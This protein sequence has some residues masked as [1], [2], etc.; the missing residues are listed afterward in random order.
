MGAF[1]D[2]IPQS[3][4]AFDDLTPK[5]KPPPKRSGPMDLLRQG[6][7][8]LIEGGA[9]LALQKGDIAALRRRFTPVM[10]NPLSRIIQTGT[11][12][13]DRAVY[14]PTTA[15]ISRNL[16]EP[17]SAAE[18]TARTA[19]QMAPNA[20]MPGTSL[21]RGAA[22]ILPTALS[23]GAGEGARALGASPTGEAVARVG[24]AVAGGGLAGFRRTPLPRGPVA[25]Q[26][27]DA[28]MDNIGVNVRVLPE[29]ARVR[30]AR[31]IEDGR[32]PE[33]VAL[34]VAAS[35]ATP[36]PIP[37]RRGVMTGNP[38][39]QHAESMALRGAYG[40]QP[41]ALM[42]GQVA[43]EQ[44]ALR[45]NIDAFA[46]RFAGGRPLP[47]GQGAT[48]AAERLVQMR[49]DA[50]AAVNAAF[51]AAR[52]ADVG[53]SLPREQGPVLAQRLRE[54]VRDYDMER[55]SSVRNVL[56]SF[57]NRGGPVDARD[58]FDARARLNVLTQSSDGV[59][60]SAASAAKRAL[61]GYIDEASQAGFL[62]DETSQ[63]RQAISQRR[64]VGETFESNDLVEQLTARD[65]RNGDRR[66]LVVD[67][68]EAAN[69]I[70][71]RQ[72]TSAGKRNLYRDVT[73]LRDVVGRDTPEWN[74]LRAEHFQRVAR[75]GEGGVE[76]GERQFSGVKFQKAWEDFLRDDPRLADALYSAEERAQI[77]NFARIAARVTSP[78]K[79]GDNPSNSAVSALKLLPAFLKGLPF[80]NEIAKRIEVQVNI[81]RAAQAVAPQP[82]RLPRRGLFGGR[83][84]AIAG[85]LA[86]GG[87]RDDSER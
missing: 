16:P 69:V 59:E 61:D 87:L 14:G 74:Q 84:A 76:A 81:N 80:A 15:D 50:E 83:Q 4:G 2:L 35:D 37:L 39:H 63:W 17:Q 86:T 43:R 85:G 47:L 18:R 67:P 51:R 54:G 53:V 9:G 11:A 52:E 70:F 22:V 66:A 26:A 77:S 23:A 60:R 32:S 48:P 68:G 73:R 33:Q 30:A 27:A 64:R 62:G 75:Q 58:L 10:D 25:A 20:L 29:Q 49:D 13:F 36:V 82:Q 44:A 19:G 7:S 42:Q 78:V 57:D 5:K 41:A 6:V 28:A 56:D 40:E 3:G 1:D 24:G 45:E 12:A 31:L 65:F 34:A 79:G 38:V 21:Q 8:G 72:G 71:G 55:V 46:S